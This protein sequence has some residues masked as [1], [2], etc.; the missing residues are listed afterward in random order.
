MRILPLLLIVLLACTACGSKT[1]ENLYDE[2]MK[3]IEAANPSA[4]V[5]YFKNALEKDANFFEAR[6]QLA[7]AYAAMGKAEQAEK[8]FNKVL[9]QNPSRDDVL[10]E[11]AKI[12]NAGGK[13]DRARELAGQYLSRHP[14]SPEGL[15]VTGVSYALNK[16]HGEALSYLTRSLQADPKRGSVKLELA[17][18]HISMGNVEQA[19]G[20][21]G[22]LLNADPR[23]F[24]AHYM[25]ASLELAA[26]ARD[27]AVAIY[28]KILQLDQNQV[29]ARFKLASLMLEKKDPDQAEAAADQLI[30]EHPKRGEGYLLKGMVAYYRK[31]YAEAITQLQQSIKLGPTL[32]GY[33]FLGMSYCGKGEL[34]TALSQFRI[35]LDRVPDSRRERLMTAQ[36][37][38]AQKRVDDA[39]SEVKKV[40]AVNDE[41]ATAHYILGNAYL[42]QGQFDEG[43]RE[44][45]RATRLDPKLVNAH[46]KKGAFYFSRGRE[47]E[48]EGELVTAVK[49]A[50]DVLKSRLLLASRYKRQ[51]KNEKAVALLKAGLNGSRGDAPLYNALAA[52]KFLSGD[53]AAA[54][55]SLEAAKRADPLFA[56]SYQKLAAYYAA[57]AD[58]PRAL[59]ELAAL[60][61]KV[62]A[63]V[64]ALLGLASLSEIAGRESDAL[65]YYEKAR[66]TGAMNGYLALA[67]YHQKKKA[68]QKALDVLDEAVKN[69]PRNPVP[70]EAKGRLLVAQKNYKQ[71][72]KAYDELTSLNP[73]RGAL[74]KVGCYLA[75]KQGDKA[76]EQAKRLITSRPSSVQGYLLLANVYQGA[77][78][79][80]SAIAQA[81][82]AI[83]IDGKS[84][85]ARVLLGELYRAKKD[86]AQAMAAFQGALK[87]QPDSLAARFALAT[88]LEG[89]GKKQEA[90]SMYRGILALNG[91]YVPA[92]NN[93]AY[94]SA[95]G[96]GKKEDAL[97]LAISAYRLEPGNPSITDTVGYALYKNGR[98]QDA[99]KL[100][101]RAA[102]LLPGNPTVRYHLGLAYHQAGDKVRSQKALQDCLALGESPDSGAARTL[103][104]QLK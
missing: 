63:D 99:V 76:V 101:E 103:L 2:G 8:E 47:A 49:A 74:L 95:D 84:A 14:D 9:A 28:K 39:V 93:L 17:A 85:E 82:Q 56:A 5:V 61:A 6:F 90:A 86:N 96:Y 100:L 98:N 72:L 53:E 43:M 89:T 57:R 64:A 44:L 75:M 18:L 88:H 35:I 52:L 29:A 81:N 104:A 87:A 66:Q 54:L 3:Q 69:D 22:E 7:K 24:K 32:E 15:E 83:R 77:G 46:L 91:S 42:V 40:I 21:L 23:N 50:P 67:A 31:N 71:A 78:D 62:P 92:L 59:A 30:K 80:A 1:K 94:L 19:R 11:L 55:G 26:G 37:L 10:L 33:H 38:L 27:R 68:P 4:A 70:L 41:D 45:D 20:V 58:Y 65:S 16:K 48:G 13:W 73:D 102:T 97:R 34:E 79:T 25:L 51:G 12:S 60:H 36:I